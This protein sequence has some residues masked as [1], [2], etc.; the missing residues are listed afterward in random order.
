MNDYIQILTQF[1]EDAK[2]KGQLLILDEV[3]LQPKSFNKVHD[4]TIDKF[5]NIN[6]DKKQK[7]ILK[8]YYNGEITKKNPCIESVLSQSINF[9]SCRVFPTFYIDLLVIEKLQYVYKNLNIKKMFIGYHILG[10]ERLFKANKIEI[11]NSDYHLVLKHWKKRF[12]TEK[13]SLEM[14]NKYKDWLTHGKTEK[15]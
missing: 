13:F 8:T 9:R 2:K 6:I 11:E 5:I 4:L 14:L 1:A 10:L 15:N 7:Y 3:V 12:K